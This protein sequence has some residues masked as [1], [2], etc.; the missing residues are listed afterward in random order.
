MG[1]VGR[2]L[3]PGSGPGPGPAPF[4]PPLFVLT[5]ESILGLAIPG[6]LSDSKKASLVPARS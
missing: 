3:R 5:L 1:E 6:Q 2:R 4:P